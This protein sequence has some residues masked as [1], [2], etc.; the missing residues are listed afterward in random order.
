MK[1]VIA[2]DSF[3]GTLKSY[4]AC[5]IIGDAIAKCAPRAELVIKPMAD[6]GEGTAE[7]MIRAADG[8][9]IARTVMGPVADMEVEAGFAWFERDGTALVEMASAS[10]LELLRAEQMHPLTTTTYG[11][12]Q[13]IKAAVEYG[14]RQILLAV[15]GSA[16][17]DGGLGAATA[18]GWKFLDGQG[19][20]VPLGGAGLEQIT[21]MVQH[22]DVVF[23]PMQILCDV[24]NPL[25]GQHGAARVYAP[26]KGASAEM[27]EQL[28]RGLLHLADVVRRQIGREIS[29]VHGAGA[30][31]GLAAGALA[32][33]NGTIV[34]GIEVVMARSNLSGELASAD[35]VITGEGCF[36]EQSLRGKVLSGILRLASQSHTKVAVLAGQVKVPAQEYEEL[37]VVAAIACQADDMSLD[38]TLEHCRDLLGVAAERFVREHIF[39]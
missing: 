33:M 12:G 39:R 31:G 13:L 35:W 1:I 8:R 14:A 38:Y 18:L 27:V 26:Q 30:A 19:N 29:D 37:G 6:G 4:E 17:V 23:R 34:S 10:G 15:G 24:D 3:K 25:C 5:Q 20:P 9:W 28:E 2:T 36:D 11:T 32:F 16:T 22:E 7:A 21:E